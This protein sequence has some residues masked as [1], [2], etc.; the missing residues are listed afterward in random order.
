MKK[1]AFYLLCVLA[2][3]VN[4]VHAGEQ[5]RIIVGY[6]EKVM[7]PTIDIQYK[8]KLDTGA[9]TSS[10]HAEII[11]IVEKSE[12]EEEKGYVLFSLKGEDGTNT[13]I[14][15]DIERMVRIKMKD[16]KTQRRP[17]ILMDFCIAGSLI[18]EEVNLTDRGHFNYEV[19]VGRNMLEK[20]LFIVDVSKV[21]TTRP[22]C[23][24]EEGNT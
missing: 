14:K 3:S 7:I 6:I 21:F 15:K 23:I 18:E 10:I 2:L 17:T 19:L 11:E 20:G 24:N 22:K 16:G 4:I 5:K 12:D 8:A 9:H 13:Q 1:I